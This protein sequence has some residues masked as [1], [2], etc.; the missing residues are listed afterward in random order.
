MEAADK[1]QTITLP[2]R[3][4]TCGEVLVDDFFGAKVIASAHL[5]ASV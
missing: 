4:I 1:L 5:K 3:D 2:D